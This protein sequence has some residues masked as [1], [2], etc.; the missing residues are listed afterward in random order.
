MTRKPWTCPKCGRTLTVR[1]QEHTCAHYSL[2][3]H[4]EG[5][6]PVGKIAFDWMCGVLDPLGPY[7]V[8]PMKTMIGFAQGVNIA[9]LRTKRQGAELS[10]VL[11]RPLSSARVTASLP[12]S[13]TKT[14]YRTIVSSPADL[15]LEIASWLQEAYETLAQPEPRSEDSSDE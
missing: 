8:L 7:D 9:F 5:K 13:K 1:N 6:D 14:I 11:S 10:V 2:D 4:F 3:A 12:Y 15:D